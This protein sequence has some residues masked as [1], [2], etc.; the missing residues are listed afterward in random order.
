MGAESRF[1][2]GITI[3]L[4]SILLLG[5]VQRQKRGIANIGFE[6]ALVLVIYFIGYSALVGGWVSD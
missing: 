1:I 6:S 2:I 5:L 3:L 4:T